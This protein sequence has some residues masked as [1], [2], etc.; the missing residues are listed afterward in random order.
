MNHHHETPSLSPATKR[1]R[2]S[3]TAQ[4]SDGEGEW[5]K[6]ERRKAKKLRKGET[7][8]DVCVALFDGSAIITHAL[9]NHRA[10][11][12][13]LCTQ[14][15]TLSNAIMLLLSMFVLSPHHRPAS[16]IISGS[17]DLREFILHIIA[18]APPPVWLRIQ[19][20]LS[21]CIE[22]PYKF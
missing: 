15:A 10:L 19:A 18:D 3:P 2:D 16:L 11:R 8:L 22:E 1:P 13:G 17:Q 6:V 4:Q 20:S 9:F 5:T 7:K 12:Q 14:M 21:L